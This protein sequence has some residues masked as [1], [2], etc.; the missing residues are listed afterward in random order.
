MSQQFSGTAEI[1]FT[2][3]SLTPLQSFFN[4][5]GKGILLLIELCF[6]PACLKLEIDLFCHRNNNKGFS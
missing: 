6:Y 4:I 2:N 3:L 1:V 5:S